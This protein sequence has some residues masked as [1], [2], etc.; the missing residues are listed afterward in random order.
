LRLIIGGSSSVGKTTAARHLANRHNLT[1]VETDRTLPNIPPLRPLNGPIEIWDRPAAELCALLIDAAVAST[2]Y[3][4]QQISALSVG[5]CDGWIVEGERVH[6]ELVARVSRTGEAQGVFIVETDP[7]R[8]YK[9]LMK[10]L[11]GFNEISESRRRTVAEVDGLYNRWLVHQT[12]QQ[13]L[14]CIDAQPWA[15]L[16]ERVIA[17]TKGRLAYMS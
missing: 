3:L 4:S 1:L 2:P 13:N 9:T 15:T 17:A 8:I 16:P 12:H 5:S 10:R 7:Q 6:P 14:R 11:P